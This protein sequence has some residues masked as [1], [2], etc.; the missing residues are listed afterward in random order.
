MAEHSNP[1]LIKK[2]KKS[3]IIVGC[4]S[5][6]ALVVAAM[7]FAHDY[8]TYRSPPKL[9][10]TKL[11]DLPV[12]MTLLDEPSLKVTFEGVLPFD[13]EPGILI[14]NIY[15]TFIRL[16]N[17]GGQAFV[18]DDRV[19]S[20]VTFSL[21]DPKCRILNIDRRD[22]FGATKGLGLGTELLQDG[23]TVRVRT[24]LLNAN[25]SVV[26]SILHTAGPDAVQ[27]T[28][29]VIDQPL[30]LE[31]QEFSTRSDDSNHSLIVALVWLIST[32]VLTYLILSLAA[33][34]MFSRSTQ[35]DTVAKSLR[36]AVEPAAIGLLSFWILIAIASSVGIKEHPAIATLLL[37]PASGIAIAAGFLWMQHR[38]LERIPKQVPPAG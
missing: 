22:E 3:Q 11:Y 15:C 1:P 19:H 5:L 4:V 14:E 21:N 26:L 36:S 24:P 23:I 37:F 31:R 35:S 17:D 34:R 6:L 10:I 29:R 25:E 33:Y 27:L 32:P 30:A 2:I 12:F 16:R 20:P 18:W 28:G 8:R 7:S 9:T 38:F 13:P